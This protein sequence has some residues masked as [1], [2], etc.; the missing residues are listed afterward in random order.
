VSDTPLH[1]LH[2]FGIWIVLAQAPAGEQRGSAL[3][4]AACSAA[5]AGAHAF[6]VSVGAASS[7][8]WISVRHRSV[9]VRMCTSLS[10]VQ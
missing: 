1:S 2:T 7:G 5:A 4:E 9:C 3:V 10:V 6:V 8:V